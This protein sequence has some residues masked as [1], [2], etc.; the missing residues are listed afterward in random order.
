MTQRVLKDSTATLVTYPKTLAQATG[1]PTARIGTAASAMPAV[2]AGSNCTVDTLSTDVAGDALA[3]DT[4]IVV[5]EATWVRG[6]QYVAT[7]TTGD[8]FVIE[9]ASDGESDTL[10][11]T[12]PLPTALLTGSTIE[13]FRI[14]IALTAPQTA[15]IASA[16]VVEWTA[17]LD[18]VSEV[19]ADNFEIVPRVGGYTLDTVSLMKSSPFCKRLQ[20]DADNDFTEMIDAAWRRFVE[21]ALL[22]KGIKPHLFVSRTE[23][24]P[25]H[26]AACEHFAAQ[27]Q[28]DGATETREEK[29]REWAAALDLVLSSTSLWIDDSA[30]QLAPPDPGAARPWTWSR[31]ER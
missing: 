18:G 24:E 28:I 27:G 3:G 9:S 25:A 22:A 16:A 23:L 12:E 31:V 2:G 29:R 8:V 21:P 20:V 19:W 17:T 7:S 30:Q 15:S 1:T 5:T 11:L 13:G 14:S 10:Y 4:E 6:R 26:I